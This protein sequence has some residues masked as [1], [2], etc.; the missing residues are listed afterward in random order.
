[1]RLAV[2]AL[3]LAVTACASSTG[4]GAAAGRVAAAGQGRQCFPV[5]SVNSFNAVDEDTINIR[6]G[7]NDYWQMELLGPCRDVEWNLGVALR[8]R[9]GG[10]FICDPLD[11]EVLS[12][13]I[14]GPDRC[15]VK[16]LRRLNATEVAALG[17]NRP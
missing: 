9:S 14:S 10:S 12:Q 5:Q 2:V 16:S 3:A 15:P 7:V 6:V 17:K 11:V 13:S 1:M 4:G 8:S